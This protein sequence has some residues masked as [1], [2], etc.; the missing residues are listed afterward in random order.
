MDF[1]RKKPEEPRVKWLPGSPKVFQVS[2]AITSRLRLGTE[3]SLMVGWTC[4]RCRSALTGEGFAIGRGCVRECGVFGEEIETQNS[5]VLALSR[6]S[7]RYLYSILRVLWAP[8][9]SMLG[10]ENMGLSTLNRI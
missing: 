10:T 6:K 7:P 3:S 4:R 8:P 5:D 1:L 2:R 9:K